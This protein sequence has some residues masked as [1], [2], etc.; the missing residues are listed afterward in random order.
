MDNQFDKTLLDGQQANP[1]PAPPQKEVEI[2]T[3]QSDLKAF[4]ESGGEVSLSGERQSFAQPQAVVQAPAQTAPQPATSIPVENQ[5]P[6]TP[7]PASAP[8]QSSG[9]LKAVLM[10][11]AAILVIVAMGYLG[12]AY[13]FPMIFK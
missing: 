2:R 4:K 6:V 3:M 5:A 11:V 1:I 12:Y 13:V 7:A 9:G 10:I 8:V